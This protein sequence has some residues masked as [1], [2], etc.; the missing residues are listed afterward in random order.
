[1]FTIE[2]LIEKIYEPK[3]KELFKD[4]YTSYTQGQYRATVVMLWT[5]VVCDLIYKLQYLKDVYNDSTAIDILKKIESKQEKNSKSSEWENYLIKEVNERTQLITDIEKENLEYLQK[6]RNLSAHPIITNEN[7]LFKPTKEL[8]R[9]L[10]RAALDSV[11]LKTPLLAKEYIDI[12]LED[13]EHK[14]DSFFPWDDNFEKY[15]TNRYLKHLNLTQILNLFK[16]LWR[17]VFSPHNEREKANS[18]INYQLLNYIFNNYK[19]SCLEFM[20]KSIDYYTYDSYDKTA[21]SAFNSFVIDNYNIYQ[22]LSDPTKAI[23][24]SEARPF[25]NN[26]PYF[27]IH[28]VNYCDYLLDLENQFL[29]RKEPMISTPKFSVQIRQL[30][31]QAEKENEIPKYID[32]SISL[33]TNS[34]DFNEAD[35]LFYE[36]IRPNFK[37]FSIKQIK[38]FIELASKNNQTYNRKRA[39][40]DHK[41]V[42]KKFIDLKG[43]YDDIKN[44]P[45][46]DLYIELG[47][48]PF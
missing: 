5:V 19:T 8:T 45:F 22:T 30:K 40:E 4:V 28:K 41:L 9:S 10:I 14:G 21:K 27:F 12:I 6:Q 35:L 31:N 23:F 25:P 2:D 15:L 44:T 36:F 1:M 42:I 43:S 26:L 47:G 34:I 39:T 48:V 17:I 33:Y 18:Y 24:E 37:K 3:T 11:L 32:F 20:Q 46:E 7:I 13:F 38:Q 29:K 16:L